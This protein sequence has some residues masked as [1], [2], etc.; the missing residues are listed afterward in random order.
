MG[1]AAAVESR[2]LIHEATRAE[3]VREVRRRDE[4]EARD[5]LKSWFEV[6]NL[7]GGRD[8]IQYET[9]EKAIQAGA[10]VVAQG[11]WYGFEVIEVFG[12]S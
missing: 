10:W 8:G 7:D 3:L 6:R 2:P 11:R 1:D 9:R 5:S 12:R 4:Q